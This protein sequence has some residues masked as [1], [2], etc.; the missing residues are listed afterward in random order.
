MT[1]YVAVYFRI[2]NIDTIKCDDIVPS[3]NTCAIKFFQREKRISYETIN[4]HKS[5]DSNK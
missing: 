4:A 5:I 2:I 1:I 3:Y